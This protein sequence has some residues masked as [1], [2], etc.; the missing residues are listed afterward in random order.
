MATL[1]LT[2]HLNTEMRLSLRRMRD[3]REEERDAMEEVSSKSTGDTED[4][5]THL[6][7]QN[8][9]SGLANQIETE[10]GQ[11]LSANQLDI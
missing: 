8:S 4:S 9:T 2:I 5:W 3:A 11:N 1:L 10:R 6:Y 7:P